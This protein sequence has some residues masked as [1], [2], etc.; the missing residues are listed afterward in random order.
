MS[1]QFVFNNHISYL[2]A[3]AAVLSPL[4]V[5]PL[6]RGAGF[7][8]NQ[9]IVEAFC[10]LLSAVAAVGILL[11]RAS[12]GHMSDRR[13]ILSLMAFFLLGLVSCVL[14]Y[15]P[16]HA[17][18]E[19]ANF[20]LLFVSSGLIASE[21]ATRGDA[22]L[23]QIL[24][25]CG[26]GCAFYILVE[27]IVYA[28]LIKIG[29]QPLNARLIF[30]FDNYRFFN[31]VQTISLP[32][33]V[34][35]ICR[36]KDGKNKIFPWIVASLW[37][38]L[39]F[40]SAGRGTFIGL[41]AGIGVSWFCLRGH[42]LQWCRVML[43][44]ALAGLGAYLL[45]YVLLPLALGLQPFGFLFSV[46]DRTIQNPDSSRWPLWLRAWQMTMEHPWLGT[47]PLHFAHFGRDVQIGAHP[48]NWL[49]QIASEWGIPALF[50][51]VAAIALGFKSLLGMRQSLGA[52][53]VKNHVTLA[54]WLSIGV[55]ILVDGL[56]SGLVVM[57]TSQLWIALYLGCVWGWVVSVRPAQIRQR[58]PMAV[59]VLGA[60]VMLAAVYLLINGLWPEMRDLPAYEELNLQKNL[61]ADPVY[62]P[63]IWLGGYF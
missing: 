45:F 58:L 47:G 35:L 55:A 54:A 49:L 16:R 20:L 4:L 32:L 63:R 53:D 15:S 31:H 50:C 9:R 18:F 10:V 48:H 30:G 25:L 44:S 60:M 28:A 5:F 13:S 3:I 24:R 27:M 41:L 37:W 33:L 23:D 52:E 19:W 39:L 17:F 11:R 21:I 38:M 46:V 34:L 40:V 51:L 42:A 8:D 59:R 43:W 62:R 7:H 6:V 14:A 61:Y 29:G 57:P 26:L 12:V 22:L 56:V 1:R 2:V 36:S